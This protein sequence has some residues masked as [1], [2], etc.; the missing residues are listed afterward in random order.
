MI[1][2]E[3][4]NLKIMFFPVETLIN[5][6]PLT[7]LRKYSRRQNKKQVSVSQA[8]F[9]DIAGTVKVSV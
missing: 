4:V 1:I 6:Y 9:T 2:G 7:E 3:H 5:R 8:V